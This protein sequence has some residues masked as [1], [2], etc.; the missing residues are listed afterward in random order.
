[1]HSPTLSGGGGDE[2]GIPRTGAAKPVLAAPELAW[3][4]F[5]A[6]PFVKSIIQ[7]IQFSKPNASGHH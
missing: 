1:M 5:A 2:S 7:L 6:A 3:G 4:L